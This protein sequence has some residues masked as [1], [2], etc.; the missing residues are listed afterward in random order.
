LTDP[1]T[2]PY[3]WLGKSVF[4]PMMRSEKSSQ[5]SL[6][7]EPGVPNKPVSITTQFSAVE[8]SWLPHPLG[9]TLFSNCVDGG[10][11]RVAASPGPGPNRS[12]TPDR[13]SRG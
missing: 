5:D 2:N 13:K 10:E 8:N 4:F 12:R 11:V 9:G 6:I 7:G 1:T 3:G